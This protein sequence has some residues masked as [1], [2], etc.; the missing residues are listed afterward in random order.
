MKRVKFWVG[1][2][3]LLALVT[4]VKISPAQSETTDVAALRQQLTTEV[5]SLRTDLLRQGIDFQE[6]KIK[7]LT[8]ELQRLKTERERWEETEMSLRR[9]IANVEQNL[10]TGASDEQEGMKAE[11]NGTH[12]RGV[13]NKSQPL[14]EQE[15]ELHKQLEQEQQQLL[16]LQTKLKKLRE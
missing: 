5:R 11:L 8:R 15:A 1:A 6:W 12:L 10:A 14:V 9:Q 4:L 3:C 2:A 16:A 7:Q 13:R